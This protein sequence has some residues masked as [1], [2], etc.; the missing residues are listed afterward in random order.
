MDRS[1][2]LRAGLAGALAH[3]MRSMAARALT[4]RR[5]PRRRQH[6]YTSVARTTGLGGLL[7]E[8]MWP[9]T[10]HAFRVSPS[11]ERARWHERALGSV[12]VLTSPERLC[13]WRVLVLVAGRAYVLR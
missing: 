12:A 8:L 10:T 13:R 9:M 6:G 4:V 11:E 1:M 2:A 5:D 7:S 3:V